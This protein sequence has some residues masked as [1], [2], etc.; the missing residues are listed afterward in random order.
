MNNYLRIKNFGPVKDAKVELKPFIVLIGGQGTGKSTI[1]KLLSIFQDKLWYMYVLSEKNETCLEAF[2]KFGIHNYF[3]DD[4]YLEYMNDG[5]RIVYDKKF[6]L[7]YQDKTT[8][9][10]LLPVF[11]SWLKESAKKFSEI[12][13]S[14]ILEIN[15]LTMQQNKNEQGNNTQPVQDQFKSYLENYLNIQNRFN[16]VLSAFSNMSEKLYIPAERNLIASFADTWASIKVAG[17]PLQDKLLN[18][19]SYFEKAKKEYPVYSI[20][21]LNIIYKC[22]GNKEG[23]LINGTDKLL[24][25]KE[26]SSGA[27]A[28]LP[29]LMVLDYCIDKNVYNGYVIEE[30]E[31][32]LFPDNQ[33]YTLRYIVSK[34]NAHGSN[35]IITTHSPYLL[36]AINISLLAGK[37]AGIEKY[38]EEVCSILSEEFHLLPETVAAYALG[39]EKEYCK[40]VMNGNTNTIDQNYL[41]TT[42][43]IIGQE[44]GKLYKLYIK[45]LRDNQ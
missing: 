14:D 17:I 27:Q 21:S 31:Q 38:K 6:S 8:P 22:E 16:L 41:D 1:A 3:N 11:F 35:C 40:D 23:M 25:L 30:P 15:N 39:D 45:S 9:E 10:E 5:I 33:L 36:S 34:N 44:F 42:S 20:P 37:I 13:K 32:N 19:I 28:L 2:I 4:T 12:S 26:C 24:P 7:S 43:S 18:Y 29:M